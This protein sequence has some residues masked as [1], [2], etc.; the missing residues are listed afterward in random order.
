MAKTIAGR[1]LMSVS[2]ISYEEDQNYTIPPGISR[3][4]D[5]TR[6]DQ[7]I[8]KNEQSL[9]LILNDL[10]AGQSRQAVRYLSRPLDVFNYKEMKLFIHGDLHTGPTS[11]STEPTQPPNAEVFLRFGTDPN[12]FYEYR[13]PVRPDWN[14]ISID[15]SKLTSIKQ[16]NTND[17]SLFQEP[18]DGIPDNFYGVKGKPTLTSIKFLSVGIYNITGTK[19][20]NITVYKPDISGQVWVNELRVIGADDH[21]GWAYSIASSLKMA[22]L[23]TLNFNM[24][25]TDPYFHKLSNQF[26]SRVESRNWSVSSDL[27]VL[28]L[29][30]F[31]LPGSNLKLNYSH[32]ESIGKPL[33]LPGTDIKVSEAMAA[34]QK[35]PDSL[36]TPQNQRNLELESQSVN[37]SDSWSASNIKL[38]IPSNYWLIRD[39]WNSISL[40]FNYNKTF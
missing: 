27:N 28:K 29:L 32:T 14:E 39:T 8:Y 6:P 3:E 33:Y 19:I 18:V 15:F 21:P 10:P 40:G 17:T 37:V 16:A 22:D 5:N 9:N 35:I 7:T 23:L 31:N 4:R 20:K 30:P 12:N 1:Y 26:G 25:R 38:R 13:Q 11:V 36:K 24:S 2:T 34:E